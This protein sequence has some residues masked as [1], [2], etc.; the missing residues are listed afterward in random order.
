[1][2]TTLKRALVVIITFNSRSRHYSLTSQRIF[3]LMEHIECLLKHNRPSIHPQ[4]ATEKTTNC[5]KPKRSE[6]CVNLLTRVK[7]YHKS[8]ESR[9]MRKNPDQEEEKGGVFML[10]IK[11][12]D[13]QNKVRDP[14]TWP[15]MSILLNTFIFKLICK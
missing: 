12:G 8:I 1:M 7:V 11:L 9:V 6:A 2:K 13:G 5:D 4:P 10:T 3:C 15:S 14:I